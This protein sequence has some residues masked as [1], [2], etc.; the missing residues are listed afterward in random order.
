MAKK[1]D[2]Q[3]PPLL[4]V[5]EDLKRDK[6]KLQ[7]ASNQHKAIIRSQRAESLGFR[8]FRLEKPVEEKTKAINPSPSVPSPKCEERPLSWERERSDCRKSRDIQN[9]KIIARP[10]MLPLQPGDCSEIAFKHYAVVW[11]STIMRIPQYLAQY[12]DGHGYSNF[13]QYML[14]DRLLLLTTC[15]MSTAI[16]DRMTNRHSRPSRQALQFYGSALRLLQQQL[17]DPEALASDAIF[18]AIFQILAFEEF[19]MSS[20]SSKHHIAGLVRLIET[21]GGLSTLG[22]HGMLETFGTVWLA[23]YASKQRTVA[24]TASTA[25]HISIPTYPHF[26]CEPGLCTRIAYLPSGFANLCIANCMSYEMVSLVEIVLEYAESSRKSEKNHPQ[27]SEGQPLGDLASGL[28]RILN[29]ETYTPAEHLL[30]LALLSCC[31]YWGTLDIEVQTCWMHIHA[32]NLHQNQG[33]LFDLYDSNASHLLIDD[34]QG[35]AGMILHATNPP[36]AEAEV[37][38]KVL[39]PT[40]WLPER[41]VRVRNDFLWHPSFYVDETSPP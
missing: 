31:C 6:R 40:T 7:V 28:V 4:W 26:P 19:G 15:A 38:A 34:L 8:Q 2:N 35:W 24:E 13:I 32:A 14:Q 37:L 12:D 5:S 36:E 22:F 27:F 1:T 17:A 18:L 9:A 11:S 20:S 25:T 33:R 23:Y 39:R 16:R 3:P 21:R 30:A 10:G 29:S 41:E